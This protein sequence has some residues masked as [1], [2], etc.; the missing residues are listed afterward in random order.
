MKEIKKLSTE[1]LKNL[2]ATLKPALLRFP[3]VY[4]LTLAIAF[5]FSLDI[6]FPLKKDFLDSLLTSLIFSGLSG[7]C[8]QLTAEKFLPL[9]KKVHILLQGIALLSA[10]PVFF[11]YKNFEESHLA[12]CSVCLAFLSVSPFLLSFSQK[13]NE[14]VLNIFSAAIT[15]FIIMM[16]VGSALSIIFWTI[17]TLLLKNPYND[18]YSIIWIFSYTVVFHDT[19]LAFSSKNH[20][21]IKIPKLCKIALLYI[22]FPLYLLLILVLYV[23]L[24]KSIITLSIPMRETNTFISISSAL[25]ILFYLTLPHYDCTAS[26]LYKK[27]APAAIIPLVV[28]QIIISIDRIHAHGISTNRYA[29]LMYTLFTCLALIFSFIKNGKHILAICPLLSLIFLISGISPLNIKKVPL[30]SQTR[31]M[32]NVLSAHNLLVNGKI[33]KKRT[34]E[35]LS[36]DERKILSRSYKKISAFKNRPF[37]FAKT[38]ENKNYYFA[39]DFE[40][41]FGFN[42]DD[43][44][45]TKD[46]YFKLSLPTSSKINLSGAKEIYILKECAENQ[47][48]P[49]T[50]KY[51]NHTLDIS[52]KL[53]S[54]L[55]ERPQDYNEQETEKDAIYIE[56]SHGFTLVLT[57]VEVS[58]WDV[59]AESDIMSDERKLR[60]NATIRGFAFK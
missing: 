54:C 17:S 9:Q 16:C 58:L 39:K 31:I 37:W 32:E 26:R 38:D 8:L 11:I 24:A 10:L 27:Y 3:A 60:Y 21:A 14:I 49:G 30:W 7:F 53:K 33:D 4:L 28:V 45:R 18:I 36:S 55:K 5:I 1:L 47:A 44:N 29:I 41:T 40:D 50:V 13:K 51:A 35:S 19:F 56:D 20:A 6:L 57:Q 59:P 23:Y 22:L 12:I 34:A 48:N 52:K 46:Y 43:V 42:L 15:A 2:K 25:F